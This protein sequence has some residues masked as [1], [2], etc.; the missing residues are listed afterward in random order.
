M[1]K[2]VGLLVVLAILLCGWWAVASNGMQRGISNW[3]EARRSQGWQAEAAK[4]QKQGFPL[5]LHMQL[6]GLALADPATGA[7]V[8]ADQLD[9]STPVYWPGYVTV[10]LPQTPITL[11]SPKLRATLTAQDAM[12]D[13]RLRPGTSAQLQSL[14]LNGGAWSLDTVLGRLVSAQTITVSMEQKAS[15]AADY[16]LKVNADALTPGAIPRA[17]L[18]LPD[19]WPLAF[20]TFTADLAVTFDRVWDRRALKKRRPQPRAIDLKLAQFI[21]SDV[22]LLATG[23]VTVDDAGLATG[24]VAIKAENWPAMLDMVE[25]AGYLPPNFRPQAEQMLTGLAQMT[26]K[27]TGLDLTLTLKEGRMSMGFIPLGRAPRIILR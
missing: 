5:R 17:F 1:I 20:D 15:A 18:G 14:A 23:S 9:I 6:E 13:L 12:A 27:T 3:L 19:D 25:N 11:A 24:S 21:W 22:E 4:I 2:L 8:T 7:A 26:G 10:G 16:D